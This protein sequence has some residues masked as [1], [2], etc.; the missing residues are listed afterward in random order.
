M[1]RRSLLRYEDGTLF[2]AVEGRRIEL[3]ELRDEIRRGAYFRARDATSGEDRTGD[4]LV[5][6]LASLGRGGDV[7]SP[8]A[9][10]VRSLIRALLERGEQVA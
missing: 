7:Y 10:A 5:Q 3:G 4:V 2:D 1:I 9:R 6:V 8:F